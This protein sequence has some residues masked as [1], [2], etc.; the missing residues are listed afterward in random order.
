MKRRIKLFWV[1]LMITF[2]IVDT[3][4]LFHNLGK[5]YLIQTGE[6]YHATNAYEMLKQGNWIVNTYCYA[7]AVF[8]MLF[9]ACTDLFT[10]HMYRAAEMDSLFNLF[11]A[12]AMISLYEMSQVPDFM[13][14]YGLALGLAFMC[15]GSHAALIFFIGLLYIPKI[16]K[17][18]LSVKRVFLSALMAAIIPCAWMVKRYMFDQSRLFDALFMGGGCWKSISC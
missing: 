2:V 12:L 4:M 17:A 3:Y 15:K 10:F 1:I 13:Y 5:G 14:I 11:F 9:G 16:K 7:T 8:P 6:A 18:F